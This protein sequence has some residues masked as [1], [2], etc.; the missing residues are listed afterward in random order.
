MKR[1]TAEAVS[2]P[3]VC[4]SEP[5]GTRSAAEKSPFRLPTGSPRLKNQLNVQA[6][7]RLAQRLRADEAKPLAEIY[8]LL[9]SL[10][11]S[12]EFVDRNGITKRT[13]VKYVANPEHAKSVLVFACPVRECAGGDFDL[14]AKL[15]E[16]V[17]ESRTKIEG[18]MHC[19]GSHKGASGTLVACRSVL[20]YSLRLAY[21]GRLRSP[22]GTDCLSLTKNTK[23]TR[24]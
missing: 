18:E 13:E 4:S 9:K 15:A 3:A 20:R 24:L 22:K 17:G 7:H 2:A 11:G 6:E 21:Y 19:L 10:K 5:G 16:A 12:L 23:S 8:P 1:E 14:T